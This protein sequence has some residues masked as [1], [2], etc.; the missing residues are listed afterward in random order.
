MLIAEKLS[1]GY[2]R[3]KNRVEIQT[4]LN[5]RFKKGEVNAIIGLNGSGKTTLLLTLSGLI[6]PLDGLI[7]L[8]D[9]KMSDLSL[10]HLSKSVSIVLTTRITQKNMTVGELV[11]LGRHP[12]SDY[13]GKNSEEDNYQIS[14]AMNLTGIASLENRFL[15]TLSDGELQK[16]MISKCLAQDTPF[17]LLDEPTAFLD[18][19]SKVEILSLL[20][21][22]AG[23]L[24]KCIIY[25]THE[26]GLAVDYSD[27]LLI[28]GK[29]Q[30]FVSGSPSELLHGG[31]INR[32][33][34]RDGICFDKSS[35]TFS[36][37]N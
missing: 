10:K 28:L 3:N 4:N 31:H 6:K 5:L 21:G 15:E 22:I 30:E 25:S 20:S 27:H 33:F 29:N 18:S 14:Q 32:F 8:N 35:L 13:F 17:I 26:I 1:V 2:G 19:P 23:R 12:Y 11:Q 37:I 7:L 36:K 24:N 16:A 34:D 9:Q